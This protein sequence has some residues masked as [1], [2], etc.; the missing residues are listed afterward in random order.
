M[1]SSDATTTT[2]HE[3]Q[4]MR[5]LST[6]RQTF[7]R[8]A[9]TATFGA[10]IS[11]IAL[12]SIAR[13]SSAQD[14]AP[15]TSTA[16]P[17]TAES[18]APAFSYYVP[19]V[20][21]LNGANNSV[22]RSALRG[23]NLGLGVATLTYI[24]HPRG[25]PGQPTDPHGVTQISAGNTFNLDDPV[26]RLNV[27]GAGW[28]EITST[29]PLAF[30]SCYTYNAA[31]DGTQ[32][33][34]DFPVFD[35]AQLETDTR[36]LKSGDNVRFTIPDLS[37]KRV[38]YAVFI[39]PGKRTTVGVR[40]QL[41]DNQGRIITNAGANFTN[42]TLYQ[43]SPVD[44][45]LSQIQVVAG[46]AFKVTLGEEGD[47]G[48]AYAYICLD[49]VDNLI[50]TKQDPY[51][52]TGTIT[53]AFTSIEYRILPD[54]AEEND[55]LTDR[56]AAV[57]RPGINVTDIWANDLGTPSFNQHYTNTTTGAFV[58]QYFDNA[59]GTGTWTPYMRVYATN[60]DGYPFSRDIT[61]TSYT[62]VAEKDGYVASYA[63]V[64]AFALQNLDVVSI[65]ASRG[66]YGGDIRYTYAQW[67]TMWQQY[68][69]GVSSPSNPELKELVFNDV[70]D[71]TYNGG[72]SIVFQ[73][74]DGTQKVLYN[75]DERDFDLLMNG[76]NAKLPQ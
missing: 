19:T 50:Q 26:G 53:P 41:Y 9:G 55:T 56:L 58:V 30:S 57:A 17:V 6:I 40:D 66:G 27:D 16:Q 8:N 10:L 74:Q 3:V 35:A 38:N 24:L 65:I 46:D 68:L 5:I 67:K 73:F 49:V 28:L 70:G 48:T 60:E 51:T 34:Q 2:H 75:N 29:Q 23:Q 31:T 15:H 62:I 61:G 14:V 1:P 52:D 36:L 63:D 47:V 71:G 21:H 11:T 32:Q 13:N 72:N 54:H 20:A 76:T 22:W 12:G 37:T 43:W 45:S 4:T 18:T 44:S 7:R 33:G 64:K 25:V 59:Q 69:D 42:G 39:L